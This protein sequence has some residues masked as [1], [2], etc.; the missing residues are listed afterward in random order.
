MCVRPD[1]A[2][3]P[4]LPL[5]IW[6]SE[7]AIA[8]LHRRIDLA[9]WPTVTFHE[10]WDAGTNDLVLRDLVARWR[11]GFDWFAVQDRLN[12]YAHLRGPVAGEG[13]EELHWVLRTGGGEGRIP[14][15]LLHG[16]PSSFLEPLR[17]ADRLLDDPPRSG[18]V[19]PAFD[20][21]VPSLPGF[22]F[23]DAPRSPGWHPGVIAEQLHRLMRTLGY[24]RYG[25]VGGD[26][27][28]IIGARLAR[29]HPEAVLGLYLHHAA[30]LLPP[31]TPAERAWADRLAAVR[32]REGGYSHL[33]GTKPQSLGY[34]LLDSPIGLLA[35]MVEKFHGWT[36][37]AL[38][39]TRAEGLWDAISPD[40]VLETVT[41]YWLTETALSASR[42][43]FERGREQ[44]PHVPRTPIAVPT[45]FGRF[46]ADPWGAPRAALA[47]SY[48][49]VRYTEHPRGGHFPAFEVPDL[50]AADVADFF[51]GLAESG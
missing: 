43:Y 10:G 35:W 20:A 6:F 41:L 15:L 37:R 42:I 32:E 14:L 21:I 16:W 33:Q 1:T 45:A 24:E 3:M 36:D 22:G 51:A 12:R 38:D 34:A 8:D 13:S 9:R 40:D 27:G 50:L 18:T 44:P 2:R 11:Y 29:Q 23:S 4:I 30:D 7:R 47:R 46:P 39:G 25:V 31:E 5:H 19:G 17:L 26:W 28:A 49:L 48:H